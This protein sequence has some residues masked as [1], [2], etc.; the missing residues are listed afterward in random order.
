MEGEGRRSRELQDD[1]VRVLI[2]GDDPLARGGLSSLLS[3]FALMRVVGQTSAPEELALSA[4]GSSPDVLLWDL[5]QDARPSLDRLR[6]YGDRAPPVF[7]LSPDE[8]SAV[9]A[10]SAGARGAALR[11]IEPEA[12][13]AALGAVAR[14]LIV[15]D[16]KL[17]SAALRRRAWAGALA[18][19]LTARELEVLQLLAEGLSNKLIADR[20]GMSEHTAK[21]HVNA[22]LGKLGAQTRTE[23][24]VQAV[25]LG[26]VLL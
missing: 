12:L 17:A 25:R 22:I 14:G 16:E 20:L 3:A 10:L 5:G 23:A 13:S 15:V 4:T 6:S 24:V 8:S 9:D 21:F 11:D 26:L 1:N 19:R 18:E 7:A 2:V